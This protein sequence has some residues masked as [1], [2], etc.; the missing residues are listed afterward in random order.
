MEP[1]PRSGKSATSILAAGLA[2]PPWRDLHPQGYPPAWSWTIGLVWP[3]CCFKWSCTIWTLYSLLFA[4]FHSTF[5]C[6]CGHSHPGRAVD[7]AFSCHM[8]VP[9]ANVQVCQIF[10]VH[11]TDDGHEGH[12]WKEFNSFFGSVQYNLF[13]SWHKIFNWWC[14]IWGPS[15]KWRQGTARASATGDG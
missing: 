6:V 11:S 7:H 3:V 15:L 13:P 4:F 12:F 14:V 8:E 10:C 1:T 5:V 9:S 2:L